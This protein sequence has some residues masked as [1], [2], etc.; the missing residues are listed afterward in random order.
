MVVE[1]AEEREARGHPVGQA[2]PY[3]AMGGLTGFSSLA[4]GYM[5]LDPSGQGEW[6]QYSGLGLGRQSQWGWGVSY[7]VVSYCVAGA[8]VI[9]PSVT[10][11]LVRQSLWVWVVSYCVV[12]H[13]GAGASVIVGLGRQLLCRQSLWGWVVS[14]CVVS[15]CGSG[16]SVIV[17]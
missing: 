15:H 3:A 7:C 17:S 11:G 16:S 14:Y 6:A 9:V 12:S 10:V 5:R 1:T 2:V 4:E 8:S 13:C